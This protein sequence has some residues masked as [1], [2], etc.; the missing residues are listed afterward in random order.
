MPRKPELWRRDMDRNLLQEMIKA[1][2]AFP[3]ALPTILVSEWAERKRI[4]PH[5]ISPIPGEFRFATTPYLREIVDNFSESSPIQKVV[6]MKGA[7]IGATTGILENLIGAII[8]IMPG[9]ALFVSSDK[10]SAET[11]VELRVDRMIESAGLSGKVFSQSTKKHNKKTG[12]TKTKKEFAGGFLLA[13]GPNV[14]AKLRSFSIR[15]LMF[16]EIDS[17]PIETGD[18]A[19]REG[20]PISLAEK[21]TDAFEAIRKILYIS[22]PLIMQSSRIRPLYEAGDKRR[23]YVPC[24]HCAEMQVL[25]WSRMKYEKDEAGRLIWPSVHYECEKCGGHWKNADKAE[26]LLK[27]EW[28]PSKEADEPGLRSYHLSSLY[29]PLEFKSWERI[30]QEWIGAAHDP[31]KLRVFLNTVL[32]ECYEEKGEAPQH[33]RIMLRREQ[34]IGGTLPET[35][36]PLLVTAGADVQADRVEMEIVGWGRDF[37]SWSISY[38]TLPGL[39]SDVD[40]EAWQAFRTVLTSQ[41]AGWP[42]ALC[43]IDSHFNTPA[44]NLFCSSFTGGLMPVE[45]DSRVGRYQRLFLQ[46]DAVGYTG[47][48]RIDLHTAP[49]KTE[50]YNFLRQGPPAE[51]SP[52]ARGYCHFPADRSEKYF[53]GLVAEELVRTRM[54][55]G[56]V[57]TEWVVRGG[58]ANEPH[59]CRVY[60]M[61]AVHVLADAIRENVYHAEELSWDVFWSWAEANIKP[62]VGETK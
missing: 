4:L 2:R 52:Y 10:G 62:K 56:G 13:V 60:A 24:K 54:R 27:G 45:G 22:T 58:R 16:D 40:S 50:L 30:C 38:L 43:L 57:K 32:G 37:E 21:R 44:V 9:P 51:G 14:G 53:R 61:G 55:N 31:M 41:H 15:Y 59:D 18:G 36:A 34:Y 29:A 33:E 42:I 25:E 35:A 6:F 1:V 17:Y 49:L 11:S 28:R 19:T 8:D 20:D 47:M 26:F 23:Y 5:G 7:Q 12:D 48:K 3:T 39:T 46:R